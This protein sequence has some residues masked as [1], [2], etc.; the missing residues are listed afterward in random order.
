MSELLVNRWKF[1]DNTVVGTVIQT[2]YQ[3]ISTS[4][5]VTVTIPLD[6]T[7]PQS[8]EGTE[9]FT[10][11]ITPKKI[12]NLLKI[13]CFILFGTGASALGIAALFKNSDANAVSA[14]SALANSV[15]HTMTLTHFEV[16]T[17]L[18]PITF[19]V[20]CGTNNGNYF[21]LNGSSARVFGGV[22]KSYLLIEE[23]QA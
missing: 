21:R 23:I 18:T 9:F 20:R 15:L 10:K 13:Q 3:E 11:E 7:I 4:T 22:G 8:S 17:S 19:K 1:E 6:D 5:S 16:V 12:G 14:V 2:A